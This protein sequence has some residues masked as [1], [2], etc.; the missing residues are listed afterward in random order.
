MQI[1]RCVAILRTIAAGLAC[2]SAV[3]PV[4]WAQQSSTPES[5]QPV[6]NA[7]PGGA[8][9][10]V[11]TP[12]PPGDTAPLPASWSPAE[13]AAA[14]AHCAAVLKGLDVVA[15]PIEPIREIRD[16]DACGTPVPMQLV[17][18]GS[19]P[20][21]VFSPPATLTCDMIAGLHKWLTRDVQPLARKH[22]GA[23]VTGV[24]TM[25]SFSC[26]NAYGRAN[27]RMSEHGRVNAIDL[28][29]FVTGKGETTQIAA[30]WGPNAREI[31]ARALAQA[32]AVKRK[33]ETA[34]AARKAKAPA[35]TAVAAAP[36]PPTPDA[37]AAAGTNAVMS[38]QASTTMPIQ[39]PRITFGI[40][41]PEDTM[42][43]PTGFGWAPPSRLGGPKEADAAAPGLPDAKAAFLHAAHNAACS[44]FTTVIG[45]DHDHEHVNHFHLDMAERK[46]PN[47]CK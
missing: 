37:G 29:A 12:S 35:A 2:I 15:V 34:A 4:A 5:T 19:S 6:P 8:W 9:S 28:G 46:S 24:K 31:A 7:R 11:A 47:I 22:L 1:T 33:A 20:K 42:D 27:T 3:S 13:I 23:P 18:I 44:V 10:T 36:R 17:S 40:R 32:E 14:R 43:Y 30:D 39:L 26:R 38:L 21:I 45:P 16:G 25:S 41:Q